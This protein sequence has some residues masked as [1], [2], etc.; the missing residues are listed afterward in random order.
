M[1]YDLV[2]L[3]AEIEWSPGEPIRGVEPYIKAY[4]GESLITNNLGV[5]HLKYDDSSRTYTGG[6]PIPFNPLLGKYRLEVVVPIPDERFI[7]RNSTDIEVCGRVPPR[8]DT[9]ICAMT[10][11]AQTDLIRHPVSDPLNG[12][13]DWR[14]YTRWAELLCANT[15]LY[16]VGWTIEGKVSSEDPWIPAG[17]ETFSTLAKEAHRKGFK[18]GGWI[19]SFLVWGPPELGLGYQYSWEHVDGKLRR[20]HHVSLDDE[21]RIADIA[22]LAK[23]MDA[24]PNV[25][26][27]G[28]DYMRPG[29]GG[30]EMV[31]DFVDSLGIDTPEGW[32]T[33]SI[34]QKMRWLGRILWNGSDPVVSA[35]WDWWTA[36]KS[37]AALY[38]II[39][40]ADLS[41]PIWVFILGWDKGHEHGQDPLMLN[42]AGASFCAVMLYESTAKEEKAMIG[43]WSKYLAGDEVNLIVGEAVDWELMGMSK[44]P[45][46]PQEFTIRLSGG[47]RGLSRDHPARGLFWHDLNRTHWGSLGP[48]SRIEWVNAGAAAFT[49]LRSERGELPL[50]TRVV[51]GD[52]WAEVVIENLTDE[53]MKD[54]KVSFIQTPGVALRDDRVKTVSRIGKRDRARVVYKLKP[55]SRSMVAF[56]IEWKGMRGV[57]FEYYPNPYRNA[58]FRAHE[59]VHAGGDVLVVSDQ[60]DEAT[61]V[62]MNLRNA[63][64][65]CNRISYSA[66]PRHVVQKYAHVVFIDVDLSSRPSLKGEILGYI[67]NGGAGV[68]VSCSGLGLTPTTSGP[69]GTRIG[70]LGKGSYATGPKD[71]LRSILKVIE[72]L[73]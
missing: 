65:S 8:I 10:I 18:F 69:A 1:R 22:K 70:S 68:F 58:P 63:G 66:A 15:I 30:L 39:E 32:D 27:V 44:E 3:E 61:R 67:R 50:R 36:H 72:R 57:D 28:F 41:K 19:G 60:T 56:Q 11:E 12:G 24:D 31:E 2:Q 25:D 6:W 17:P 51:T 59:S 4:C 33:H 73:K 45:E 9:A 64:Y 54:I 26:Y 37:A 34:H 48:Y 7:L 5:I 38:R 29:P 14:N 49:R 62:G 53:I 52:R 21:K 46:A 35:R 55:D 23:R 20:N 13:W 42:D 16:S 71:S 47:I 43:Q 40:E